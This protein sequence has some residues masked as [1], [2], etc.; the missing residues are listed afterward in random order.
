MYLD[1]WKHPAAF[2]L[3]RI[4][5]RVDGNP[6]RN[7]A[8]TQLQQCSLF[9]PRPSWLLPWPGRVREVFE[10]FWDTF[11][12]NEG[13]DRGE[14]NEMVR[15]LYEFKAFMDSAEWEELLFGCLQY[16]QHVRSEL[17]VRIYTI[18]TCLYCTVYWISTLRNV[19]LSFPNHWSSSG[20]VEAIS[21]WRPPDVGCGSCGTLTE[22][23]APFWC[24]SSKVPWSKSCG[25][26]QWSLA[27]KAWF[28]LF[29]LVWRVNYNEITASFC[30]LVLDRCS[31]LHRALVKS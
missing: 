7:S 14:T 17:V 12:W 4:Q 29:G 8:N 19:D 26:Q 24:N 3:V 6:G 20:F 21:Q 11:R 25:F 22:S 16:S 5:I 10:I 30:R 9:W 13:N 15:F 28:D 1:V 2:G 23:M 18:Y 31:G 27:W